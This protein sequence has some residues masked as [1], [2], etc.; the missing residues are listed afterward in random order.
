MSSLIPDFAVVPSLPDH[1][2]R[3]DFRGFR[4]KEPR[5]EGYTLW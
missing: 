3:P 1:T 4:R 2:S 5:Q